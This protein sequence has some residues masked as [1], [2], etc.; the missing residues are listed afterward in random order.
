MISIYFKTQFNVYLLS[1]YFSEKLETQIPK[2]V[3]GER[4]NC[5]TMCETKQIVNKLY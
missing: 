1:L 3:C 5:I 2:E 4:I